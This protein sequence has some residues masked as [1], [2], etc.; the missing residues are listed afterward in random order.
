MRLIRSALILFPPFSVI[1]TAIA[2][3]IFDSGYPKKIMDSAGREIV[4]QIL[5]GAK[6]NPMISTITFVPHGPSLSSHTQEDARGASQTHQG[7]GASCGSS[8]HTSRA[9]LPCGAGSEASPALACPI[10]PHSTC[11]SRILMPTAK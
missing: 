7:G 5:C 9:A 6:A 11:T 10:Y 8:T 3:D 1:N 4:M 2:S